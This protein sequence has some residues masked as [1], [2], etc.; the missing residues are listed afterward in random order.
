MDTWVN[1]WMDERV[2]GWVDDFY[3]CGLR[4]EFNVPQSPCEFYFSGAH[5]FEGSVLTGG[6]LK[7]GRKV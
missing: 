6:S 2:N 5:G 4:F 3:F 7:L 1:E